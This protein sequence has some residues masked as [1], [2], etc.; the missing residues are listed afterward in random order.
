MESNSNFATYFKIHCFFRE[1][2]AV[3]L[4]GK[5]KKSCPGMKDCLKAIALRN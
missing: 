5:M 1:Y 4:E 2:F 3:F